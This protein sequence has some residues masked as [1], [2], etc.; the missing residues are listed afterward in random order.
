VSVTFFIGE[1]QQEA[2][3]KLVCCCWDAPPLEAGLSQ[4]PGALPND[5]CT[6]SPTWQG[7]RH[8]TLPRLRHVA[9]VSLPIPEISRA[10]PS[11]LDLRGSWA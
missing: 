8:P 11:M 6:P 9:K 1:G 4:G 3:S 2:S 5:V 10:V 7:I